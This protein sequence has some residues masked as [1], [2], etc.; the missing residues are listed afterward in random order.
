MD[1]RQFL[2]QCLLITGGLGAGWLFLWIFGPVLLPFLL[3]FVVAKAASL[4]TGLLEQRLHLPR[5]AASGVCVSGIYLGLVTGLWLLCKILCREIHGFAR[6]LPAL[7]QS[8]QVPVS[9]LEQ[10][11][12]RLAGRFPDGIGHAL[13]EGVTEFFRSG[14]GLAGQLYD[15][16]FSLASAALAK[17]L[18]FALFTLTA[19]LSS[20]MLTAKLPELEK[21]WQKKL[22]SPWQTRLRR[23]AGR[24]GQTLGAW[25]KAQC[26]LIF[27]NF[28]VL[29]AG[30]VILQVEYPLLFSLLIALVDALPVLGSGT[31]LIPW[32]LLRFLQAD[33]VRGTGLLVLYGAAALLRTALEPRLLGKQMG[34]DPLLTL[35]A[36][37]GGYHFLG[38]WG[39]IFFPIGA[40][41]AK[42]FWDRAE[43]R[44]DNQPP[45][46]DNGS[47]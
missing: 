2:Q 37:Y 23:L 41:L 1:K 10:W 24:I 30:L 45:C 34:L 35:L 43:K 14:A 9:R 17:T 44:I 13:T 28:L 15:K 47:K 27:I 20:F 31:V 36:I 38:I 39:M 19:V 4:P 32:G 5:W 7:A 18:D 6:T 42:Q 29:T 8:L 12:L 33:T 25:C 40:L 11:L 3:G 26:K 46:T 22:P 16:A 21:L